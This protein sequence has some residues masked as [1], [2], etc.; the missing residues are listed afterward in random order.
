MREKFINELP[1]AVDSKM[2]MQ[3]FLSQLYTFL[4]DQMHLGLKKVLTPLTH[5]HITIPCPSSPPPPLLPLLSSPSSP[6]PLPFSYTHALF[7]QVWRTLL[8]QNL[9]YGFF[10]SVQLPL[11]ALLKLL[12]ILA[13]LKNLYYYLFCY[14]QL[15]FVALLKLPLVAPAPTLNLALALTLTSQHC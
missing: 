4:V 7:Q 9:E 5:V 14:N 10:I 3:R 15:L 2:E 6:A 8:K 12:F 13:M 11:V 1:A